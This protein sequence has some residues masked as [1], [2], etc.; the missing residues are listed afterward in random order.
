MAVPCWN[1]LSLQWQ[2]VPSTTLKPDKAVT[3][4]T[5]LNS[6]SKARK[7][8]SDTSRRRI[9]PLLQTYVIEKSEWAQ[10][11]K[12]CIFWSTGLA[13]VNTA[14]SWEIMVQEYY[15]LK[16]VSRQTCCN[17]VH[18]PSQHSYS[19]TSGCQLLNGWILWI[20]PRLVLANTEEDE[21][22]SAQAGHG[23]HS[24]ILKSFGK[25]AA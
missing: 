24:C 12:P 2:V 13:S 19:A 9:W 11:G 8:F 6:G 7:H 1:Q 16:S 15:W 21:K 23:Y 25:K 10:T 22:G 3:G 20:N 5:F 14:P 4:T 18:A 17:T